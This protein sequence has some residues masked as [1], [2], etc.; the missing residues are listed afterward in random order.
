MEGHLI[1]ETWYIQKVIARKEAENLQNV[2]VCFYEQAAELYKHW[3][4]TATTS[5]HPWLAAVIISREAEYWNK[6]DHHMPA[7]YELWNDLNSDNE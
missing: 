3:I 4:E 2:I 1:S 6:L 7:L 5:R